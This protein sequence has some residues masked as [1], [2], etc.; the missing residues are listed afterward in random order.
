MA[1]IKP[2]R[3]WRY[4]ES[5]APVMDELTSP[6]FD[7]VSDKQRQA[8]YQNPFNSIHLSVPETP[9]AADRAFRILR[10]WKQTGILEQ[11]KIPGSMYTINISSWR[12][13]HVNI[14]GRALSLTS[15]C[16]TGVKM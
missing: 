3:A 16:M 4:Q 8:L 6:L 2:F 12:D 11:D 7:V 13:R 5:F 9:D 10:E 15:G 14:A 1:E